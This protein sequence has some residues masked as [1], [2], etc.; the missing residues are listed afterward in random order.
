MNGMMGI[1]FRT[2]QTYR[3]VTKRTNNSQN[4]YSAAMANAINKKE[5]GTSGSKVKAE[6]VV[7]AYK[8]KHPKETSLVNSQVKA[9][10][11]VQSRNGAEGVSR[12][13]MTMD[14]YKAFFWKMMDSIPY[15][16]SQLRDKTT[17]N[18]SEAGWEQMKKDPDYEAWVLGYT[19]QDRAVAIPFAGYNGSYKVGIENFGASIEEH[20]GMSYNVTPN[21]NSERDDE[22]SWWMKRHKRMKELIAEQAKSHEKELAQK[23]YENAVM[24]TWVDGTG[25]MEYSTLFL[26]SGKMQQKSRDR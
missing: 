26:S 23:V 16:S 5:N 7:E 9:G 12:D 1:S 24:N 10:K 3:N 4:S 25:F 11:A 15:H 6:S 19:V 14:E 17:Y 8:R 2:G 22:E 18:I 13:E 21:K 20:H